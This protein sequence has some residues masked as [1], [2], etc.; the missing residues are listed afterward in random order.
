MSFV[1]AMPELVAA[2]AADLAG[3]GSTVGSATA[4]AA[5][6]T[7]QVVAA[8]ADEVSAAPFSPLP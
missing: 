4:T 3:I 7:T 5:V 8:G 6:P 2:A 1:F